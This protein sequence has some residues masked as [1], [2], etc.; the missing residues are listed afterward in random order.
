MPDE[1]L[2]KVRK[3]RRFGKVCIILALHTVK[4]KPVKNG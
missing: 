1:K 4:S 3:Q 2:P